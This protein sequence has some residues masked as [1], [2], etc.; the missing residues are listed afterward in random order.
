MTLLLAIDGQ[1]VDYPNPLVRSRWAT[2]TR[3]SLFLN[4]RRDNPGEAALVEAWWTGHG[5]RPAARTAFGQHLVEHA[6]DLRRLA[7][8]GVTTP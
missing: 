1:A 7:S 2:L 8:L 3:A 4:W 6:D 5:P